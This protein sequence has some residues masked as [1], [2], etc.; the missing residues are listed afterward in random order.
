MA[1]LFVAMFQS[2]FNVDIAIRSRGLNVNGETEGGD[3]VNVNLDSKEKSSGSS[4]GINSND[5]NPCYFLNEQ[6]NM[7]IES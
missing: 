4:L 5:F 2:I 6:E 3:V 7:L 1:G